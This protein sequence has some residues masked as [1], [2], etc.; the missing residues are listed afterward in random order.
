[1]I[2]ASGGEPFRLTTHPADDIVPSWSGDG[3]WVYFGSERTGRFEVWKVPAGG[4]EPVQVTTEG[5]VIALESPDGRFVYYIEEIAYVTS[6]WKRPL[7]GG[8]ES[9]VL[10]SIVYRDF[11]IIQE[12]VYFIQ[13]PDFV[14]PDWAFSI[15]FLDSSTGRVEMISQLPSNV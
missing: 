6:L 11:A 14:E 15:R 5:G 7:E 3:E 9:K 1:M 12:G 10:E 2:S 8:E 13:A 4:G